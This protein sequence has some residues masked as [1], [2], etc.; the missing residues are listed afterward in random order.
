MP[1]D[2][3]RK[4]IAALTGLRGIAAF[5]VFLF[6]Y[7]ALHPGIRLDLWLPLIGGAL[8]FPLGYGMMG[9]DLFFVM[10]GFLLTLPFARSALTGEPRPPLLR[11]FKRRFLRV[12]PAYYAQLFLIL[13]IG[14]WFVTW[15]PLPDYAVLAHLAMFLNLGWHQVTP[16]VGVWWS[17]PVEMG[18]YL[19]LPL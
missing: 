8:Q 1:P 11:Y 7:G 19:L 15:R 16:L 5:L 10:S 12:F 13:S 4:Y 17:L 9:V 3:A 6:H 18:F 2:H 14:A